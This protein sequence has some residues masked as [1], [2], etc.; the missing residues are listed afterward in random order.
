MEA[1]ATNSNF[2]SGSVGSFH[3]GPDRFQASCLTGLVWGKPL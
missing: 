3:A 2:I 1:G